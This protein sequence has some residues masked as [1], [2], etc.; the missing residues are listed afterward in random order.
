MKGKAEVDYNVPLGAASV[1]LNGWQRIGV[2]LSSLWL[3][4]LLWLVWASYQ[5]TLVRGH[6]YFVEMIPAHEVIVDPGTPDRCMQEDPV[7]I[8]HDSSGRYCTWEHFKAGIPPRR[9]QLPDQYRLLWSRF[10]ACL[11]LP[12]GLVCMLV[13]CFR[14][15]VEGFRREV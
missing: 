13:W 15:I 5:Q 12:W 11:L 10:L 2:V 9:E 8:V 6:S 7:Y 1:K 14:W 4:F 3:L